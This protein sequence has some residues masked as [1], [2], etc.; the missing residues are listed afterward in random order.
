MNNSTPSAGVTYRC[1]GVQMFVAYDRD[2][3]G[4]PTVEVWRWASSEDDPHDGYGCLEITVHE[5]VET[6]RSGT[7]AVYYR[8]WFNP[9]GEPIASRSRKVASLGSLKSLIRRRKMTAIARNPS[10]E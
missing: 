2:A 6:T 3:S 7:L 1:P 4:D 8:Q 5:I 10:H 9:E